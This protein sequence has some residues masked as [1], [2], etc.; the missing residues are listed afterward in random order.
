[1]DTGFLIPLNAPL[2][3]GTA[4][5]GLAELQTFFAEQRARPA[6]RRD[7]QGGGRRRRT[8]VS[9]CHRRATG[10]GRLVYGPHGLVAQGA[11]E[12]ISSS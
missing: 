8:R 2:L 1:M 12:L 7:A 3:P 10:L 6:M 4:A 9:C 11:Q 5:A